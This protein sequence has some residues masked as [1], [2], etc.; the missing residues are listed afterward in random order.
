[1]AATKIE[2]KTPTTDALVA[3]YAKLA[4]QAQPILDRMAEIAE[5][6]REMDPDTYETAHGD[7]KVTAYRRFNANKALELMS[8]RSKRRVMVEKVDARK[9]KKLFPGIHRRSQVQYDNRVSFDLAEA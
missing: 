8:E 1:M 6:F 2:V 4:D 5:A 9:V 7:V 3:E